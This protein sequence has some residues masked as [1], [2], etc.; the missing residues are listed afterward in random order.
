MAFPSIEY[1]L[2]IEK[3]CGDSNK[4]MARNRN[5]FSDF[6]EIKTSSW[7]NNCDPPRHNWNLGPGARSRTKGEGGRAMVTTEQNRS[8]EKSRRTFSIVRILS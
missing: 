1:N 5:D 7:T 4:L 8:N 2:K 6:F 3:M